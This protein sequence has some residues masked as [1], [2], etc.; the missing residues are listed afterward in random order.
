MEKRKVR[1]EK[2]KQSDVEKV[3]EEESKTGKKD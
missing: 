1:Q 3:E 2:E